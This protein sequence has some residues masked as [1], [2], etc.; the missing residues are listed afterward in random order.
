MDDT[1]ASL[2]CHEATWRDVVT[3]CCRRAAAAEGGHVRPVVAFVA[4]LCV[5]F[6]V[7]AS[8]ARA[9]TA[10]PL[11]VADTPTAPQP[12]APAEAAVP[13]PAALPDEAG[14]RLG[15]DDVVA[16]AVLQAPELNASVRVAANGDV[17]LPLIGAV[18]ALGLTAHDLQAAIASRLREKYIRDP[19]VTVR[20][21][22]MQSQPVSV[23]GAVTRPGI[24][25]LRVGHTLLETL[26]LAGGLTAEAGDTVIVKRGQ[27]GGAGP[28]ESAVCTPADAD[29][30]GIVEVNLKALLAS[31]PS[32]LDVVVRPGDVVAVR[33]AAVVYVVG[34]VNKPGAFHVPGHEQLTVLRAL[35]LGGGVTPI[36]AT[37]DVQVLRHGG[38]AGRA[39]MTVDL[40]ALLD[41]RTPDIPLAAQDVL[42]VPTSGGKRA[43]RYA[44]AAVLRLM[45][46]RL[47]F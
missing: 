33:S 19:H 46:L 32:P 15:P 5:G 7:V 3:V 38:T 20:L 16:V 42:F 45:P 8:D 21:A 26:A 47:L 10:L 11:T 1:R 30:C 25:Q 22:E 44:A 37:Q 14:H 9:Q 12:G 40:D 36:A 18:R 41:G 28:R 43:A 17:S 4:A 29:G 23:L 35:A 2:R 31:A 39:E 24:Y 6:P 34:A 13:P 27:A